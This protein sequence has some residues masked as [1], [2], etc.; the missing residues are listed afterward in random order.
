MKAIKA[1]LMMLAITTCAS[2]YAQSNGGSTEPAPVTIPACPTLPTEIDDSIRAALDA[3][4]DAVAKAWKAAVDRA[5][6]AAAAAVE[7]DVQPQLAEARAAHRSCTL[8]GAILGAGLTFATT[9]LLHGT[10]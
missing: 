10:D 6:V 7:R 2:V 1:C 3:Y 8:E 5:V 9:L 4:C